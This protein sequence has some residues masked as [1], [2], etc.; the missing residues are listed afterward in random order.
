MKDPLLD[1][2]ERELGFIREEGREF[3]R[4]Y[5]RLLVGFVCRTPRTL[6]IPT[7]RD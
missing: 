7:F 6:R 2:Y 3:A 4:R 5:R 1:Y